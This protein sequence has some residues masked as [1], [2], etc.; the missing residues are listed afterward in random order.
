MPTSFQWVKSYLNAPLFSCYYF[1]HQNTNV[2]KIS[3]LIFVNNMFYSLYIYFITSS[4]E[5]TF[6][7]FDCFFF[8]WFTFCFL[9]L[10]FIKTIPFVDIVDC[11]SCYHVVGY[12]NLCA[13]VYLC[14]I[15]SPWIQLWIEYDISVSV[16]FV[17]IFMECTL[18]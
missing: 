14:Q 2:F 11:W 1:K 9:L 17:H 16:W 6:A 5:V 3:S 12:P 8:K 4:I 15:N 10:S 7:L 13:N 18:L